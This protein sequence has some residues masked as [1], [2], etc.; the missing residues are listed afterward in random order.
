[1]KSIK[2]IRN[3]LAAFLLFFVFIISDL[4][5]QPKLSPKPD[6]LEN[7]IIM[8]GNWEP[9]IF[10]ARRGHF[11]REDYIE[12]YKKEHTEETVKKLKE[13]GVN[14]IVTH[15]YKGFG[16][17]AERADIEYAK[18]LARFCRKYGIRVGV[19]IGGVMA[20]ETLFL[21]KPQ[22]K[23][24]IRRDENGRILYYWDEQTFRYKPNFFRKDFQEYMKMVVRTAIKEIKPDMMFF[25]NFNLDRD[26]LSDHSSYTAILFRKFLREKYTPEKLKER[27]GFVNI[28]EVKVPEFKLGTDLINLQIIRSPIIQEWIDFRCSSLAEYYKKLSDCVKEINPEIV[29]GTNIGGITDDNRLAWGVDFSRLLPLGNWML[30]E[31]SDMADWTENNVLVSM[32]RSYKI[33]NLYDNLF[34]T[35]TSGYWAS[36]L[37]KSGFWDERTKMN[38]PTQ[39]YIAEALSF[40]GQTTGMVNWIEEDGTSIN[41]KSLVYIDFFNNNR[42]LYK[43]TE[44]IADIAVLRSFPSMAYN[45]NTPHFSTVLFE[46]LLIQKKI[47]FD[48]IFDANLEDLSK[49]KVLV[50]ADQESMGDN[51]LELVREFVKNGGGLVAV[52][53]STIYNDWRIR[54]LDFGLNDL[55]NCHYYYNKEK[56]SS[57]VKNIFEKGKVV[58]IPE[59]VPS[60]KPPKDGF[61]GY[62]AGKY[63]KLPANWQELY[64]AIEWASD[65]NLTLKIDSPDCVTAELLKQKDSNRII[66]HLVNYNYNEKCKDVKVK[67]LL[68]ENKRYKVTL[69]SPDIKESIELPSKYINNIL[70]FNVP[71]IKIYDLIV[72]QYRNY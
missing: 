67:L 1:M 13:M 6:W 32:I 56:P 25:D 60:I 43:Q 11:L 44:N 68:T 9:L 19:Y 72:I 34:L 69:Y 70:S 42:E 12:R 33:A 15:F 49:Y 46:Q 36:G 23:E 7:G 52:G 39:L 54:R 59:I 38:A 35:Y 27:V 4:I 61:N 8:T 29:V 30:G 51:E 37:W 14:F 63:W 50:L 62:I 2:I 41:P 47:L 26:P 10:R 16:L 3:I 45:N 65:D 48:I 5:A 18:E 20:Y 55:F 31:E 53:S 21:E 40:G 58:Y 66:L 24:W 22:A 28:D 57:V 64:D 71:E 17:E